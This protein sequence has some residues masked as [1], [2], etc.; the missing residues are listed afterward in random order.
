[1]AIDY[2]K[3]KNIFNGVCGN[4]LE[5]IIEAASKSDATIINPRDLDFTYTDS[6][7]SFTILESQ[8]AEQIKDPVAIVVRDWYR[9]KNSS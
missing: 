7:K 5:V 8:R 2:R 1:M 9:K 4:I 3:N 6:A